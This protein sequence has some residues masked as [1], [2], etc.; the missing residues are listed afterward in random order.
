MISRDEDE[1]LVDSFGKL[2][3]E[4]GQSGWYRI[5]RWSALLAAVLPLPALLYSLGMY[6][7]L[8]VMSGGVAGGMRFALPAVLAQFG[9]QLFYLSLFGEASGRTSVSARRWAATIAALTEPIRAV[10]LAASMMPFQYGSGS[11]ALRTMLV[12]IVGTAITVLLCLSFAR[13]ESPIGKRLT[14]W[15]AAGAAV[16]A[17]YHLSRSLRSLVRA[18][19]SWFGQIGDSWNAFVGGAVQLFNVLWALA[20]LALLVTI[21]VG[22]PGRIG[23]GRDS[24]SA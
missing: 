21:A 23:A 24:A 14:S 10:L 9:I 15:L 17:A 20:V 6:G 5:Y 2:P 1:R 4:V 12:R 8:L 18:L 3:A 7:V 22:R 19:P 13:Q 16:V 11:M